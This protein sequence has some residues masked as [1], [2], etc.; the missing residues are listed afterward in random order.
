MSMTT[1]QSKDR[2]IMTKPTRED[3]ANDVEFRIAFMAW[4]RWVI[5][6]QMIGEDPLNEAE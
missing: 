4:R 6:Q 5:S 2:T 1:E 3:Y